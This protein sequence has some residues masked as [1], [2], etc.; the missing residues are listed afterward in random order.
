MI[1]NFFQ[2]DWEVKLIEWCQNNIP[3][4]IIKILDYISYVGDVIGIVAILAF[5]YL[6][7]NK[8]V[9]K[10]LLVNIVFVLMFSGYIKNVF[11]RRRPYFDNENVKCL[12]VVEYNINY[13]HI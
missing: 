6:C 9:G 8:K 11:K 5:F 12:K 3:F 4:V 13:R 1:G 2:F 10:R 7:Y